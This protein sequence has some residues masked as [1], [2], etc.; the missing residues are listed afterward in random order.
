VDDGSSDESLC[1][2][3]QV[4]DKYPSRRNQV[5]FVS[6]QNNRGVGVARNAGIQRATGE[7]IIHCDS[8]DWVESCLYEKLYFK[9][10]ETNADVVTCGYYVD[11]A[12][13]TSSSD[14]PPLVNVDPLPF[15]ISPQ[16]GALWTK[17]IRRGFLE[18]HHLDIPL[19][20]NWGEDLCLSLEAL[21][22]SRNTQSINEI[23]YH[24]VLNEDSLTYSVSTS[25]CLELVKCGSFVE[26]FLDRHRLLRK[27]SFQLNW[28]KFQLKQYLLIF[29]QTRDVN[30]WKSIYPECH[31]H[32]LQYQTMTYLKVSAWLIVHHLYLFALIVLKIRDFL[33]PF[34]NR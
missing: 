32:I 23:L 6:Y 16:T 7:Y 2:I 17:L 3:N 19:D 13:G 12:D 18:E 24:H 5:V 34:K 14:T 22:L 11:A 4:L 26:N 33:S 28:L 31:Q 8:D 1:I 21:L 15:S 29:P 25:Q 9:A 30:L 10:K 27:Y 20:I